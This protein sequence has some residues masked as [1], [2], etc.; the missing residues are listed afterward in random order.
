[1]NDR[2]LYAFVLLLLLFPG[3]APAQTIP[4]DLG[5]LAGQLYEKTKD[6]LKDDDLS[7]EQKNAIK[8]ARKR[9]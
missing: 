8:R 1:M 9:Y 3:T 5:A 4:S 2:F 6:T 7:S